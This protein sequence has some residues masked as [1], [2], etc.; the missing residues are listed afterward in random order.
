MTGEILFVLLVLAGVV[1]LFGSG[2]VRPDL[3]ALLAL[4]AV[5]ISGVVTPAEALAGFSNHAVV[6]VAG[7][8]VISAGLARTGVA[9]FLGR[10]VLH[11][12]GHGETRLVIALMVLSG[13]LSG[14][15]NNVGVAAMMMPVVVEI[16]RKTDLPP[17]KLLI[18]MALGAQ[19]GGL[20]TLIGTAPNLLAGDA[21][22]EAGIE[23]FG[24]FEFTPMG[25]ILLL[26]GT[27]F[28]AVAGPRLLPTRDPTTGRRRGRPQLQED[29]PLS[30][31]TFAVRIPEGS[32][33]EGKT[34][35]ESL[36]GSALGLQVLMIEKR[37]KTIHAPRPG[38]VLGGGDRLLVQGDMEMLLEFQRNRH[39][40]FEAEQDPAEWLTSLRVGLAEVRVEEDSPLVGSSLNDADFRRKRGVV[41]LAIRRDGVSRR[42]HLQDTPLRPGDWLL[43]QGPR[44]RLAEVADVAGLGGYRELG[45][46]DAMHDFA[47]SSRLT[48]LRV[49]EDSL[50]H[51]RS[52]S[53]THLGD[54]MGLTVL[55]VVREGTAH[56]VPDPKFPLHED[57]ILLVKA[58]PDDLTALRGLQRLEVEEDAEIEAR[59]L[60]SERTG[61]VEVV[62]APRSGLVGK[63]IRQL[64][65]RG[66]FGVSVLAIWR[67]DRRIGV[68]LRDEVLHFGDA[69]LLYGTRDR[70]RALF[71]EPDFI[72]LTEAVAEAPRTRLA[73]LSIVI[74]AAALI[75]VMAGWL[76][77]S[78]AV[79]AASILLV[80]TRCLTAEEAYRAVDWPTIVLVAGMLSLG[81]ALERSGTAAF[82]GEQIV[83][84]V[85]ALGPRGVLLMLAVITTIGAQ[86]IPGSA[87]V[88][89]MAPIAINAG[90][91][92]GISPRAL[93]M[94]V[95]LTCTTMASPVAHP[96]HLLVMAPAGYRMGD[97]LRLGVPLTL[98]LLVA[99]VL[100]LPIF[101]PF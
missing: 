6:A 90:L 43:V 36:I 46:A 69:L 8:F 17:S 73:P 62:L 51:G 70:L 14:F 59:E 35:A 68:G 49:T 56:V 95:A 18:P 86:V 67:E 37:G 91:E 54:A 61:L 57:D 63:T 89:L 44:D 53:E 9:S 11:V 94:G 101:F 88:V 19:L 26:L 28:V 74:V 45:A 50:L 38:T 64:N 4:A 33:L 29:L 27:V 83:A 40:V 80:F 22:L 41:V 60:E 5:G 31:R 87:L 55:A 10:E 81:V 3:V 75:P 76:P 25:L 12:A 66:R 2:R 85:A 48:A 82:L 96:A 79:V 16:A 84:G 77:I 65:F 92:L 13:A 47:L 58:H 72:V 71:D 100:F 20:T 15:M 42:T 30:E 52:V 24:L 99:V 21:L 32:L 7:M 97:F 34:L 23:E 1:A 93:V 98:M 39:L 78:L